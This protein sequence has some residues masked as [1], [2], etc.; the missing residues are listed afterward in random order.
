MSE[1]QDPLDLVAELRAE[2]EELREALTH[3]LRVFTPRTGEPGPDMYVETVAWTQAEVVLRRLTGGCM[4]DTY[5]VTCK[6]CGLSTYQT[7]GQT[8]SKR[9]FYSPKTCPNCGE[10]LD[11]T[12]QD[13]VVYSEEDGERE[14]VG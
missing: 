5:L 2:N 3:M 9:W 12:T 13:R 10:P 1:H 11:R 6:N 8:G 4:N 14:W 7:W